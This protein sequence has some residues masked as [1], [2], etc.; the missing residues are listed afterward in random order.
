LGKLAEEFLLSCDKFNIILWSEG[1]KFLIISENCENI[2]TVHSLKYSFVKKT[3]LLCVM[4]CSLADM[5]QHIRETI[6]LC[7]QSPE[8]TGSRGCEILVPFYQT[9]RHDIPE[10]ILLHC[11]CHRTSERSH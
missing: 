2:I 9:E 6:C 8:G 4:P 7:L 10:D 3:Y 5:Y 11:L 1:S